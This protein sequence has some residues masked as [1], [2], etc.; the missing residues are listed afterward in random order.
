MEAAYVGVGP[1]S[2]EYTSDDQGG[3]TEAEKQEEVSM[4]I[5]LDGKVA[6]RAV[7]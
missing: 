5:E 2:T 6:C 1:L 4:R 3:W 7:A